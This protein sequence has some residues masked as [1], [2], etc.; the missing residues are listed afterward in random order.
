MTLFLALIGAGGRVLVPVLTQQVIDKGIDTETGVIDMGEV[1]RLSAI[2]FV[3][4]LITTFTNWMTRIRLARSAEGALARLRGR[5]FDH[6]HRLSI[7][8]HTENRRGVLVA[9]RDIRRRDAVELLRLGRD[10]LGRQP[11]DDDGRRP[12]DARSTTGGWP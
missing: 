4:L 3:L 12:H 9:A 10:R 6:I 2:A 8:R 7:A 11:V 1:W 5:V